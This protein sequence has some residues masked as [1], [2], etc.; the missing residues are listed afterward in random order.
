VTVPLGVLKAGAIRFHPELPPTVRAAVDGLAMGAGT[1][2]LLRFR[3]RLWPRGMSFLLLDDEVPAVWPPHR[4]APLLT[5]F[6]MGPRAERLRRPPGPVERVLAALARAWPEARR[7]LAAAEVVDWGADPW[8]RGGYSSAP[9]GAEG[10][11]AA[12]AAPCGPL[13]FAGE[14]TDERSPGT[15]SG[16]L[17]SGVSAAEEA[18]D[19]LAGGRATAPR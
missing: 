12:L 14:A 5:A 6:V 15:V 1:K 11:R 16:A 10:L 3:A 4:D 18:L 9:P 17:R 8:T 13:R 7:E 19:A 2:V